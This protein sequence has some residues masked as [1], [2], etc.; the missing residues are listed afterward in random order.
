MVY[1][2]FLD[3]V[4]SKLDY[5]NVSQPADCRFLYVGYAV[6][7]EPKYLEV[8]EFLQRGCGQV[9]ELVVSQVQGAKR[10]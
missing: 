7:V 4:R 2:C 5:L 8:G 9:G 1:Q 6:V 10:R 3:L